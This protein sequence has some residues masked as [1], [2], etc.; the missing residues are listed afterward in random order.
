LN[1]DFWSN[2]NN[3]NNVDGGDS[4]SKTLLNRGKAA[5]PK[6]IKQLKSVGKRFAPT[7]LR[8]APSQDIVLASSSSS[9]SA[10]INGICRSA[11]SSK[12]HMNLKSAMSGASQAKFQSMQLQ[13]NTRSPISESNESKI[14]PPRR[15]S[16]SRSSQRSSRRH[17]LQQKKITWGANDTRTLTEEREEND[18]GDNVTATTSRSMEMELPRHE[19]TKAKKETADSNA[20]NKAL[21]KSSI[22][23]SSDRNFKE[24]RTPPQEAESNEELLASREGCEPDT[25]T[26][27]VHRVK[28]E[29]RSRSQRQ[30]IL[31]SGGA[32]RNTESQN[33]A[34]VTKKQAPLPTLG[35]KEQRRARSIQA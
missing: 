28:K 11:S 2:I 13:E 17:E 29:S 5:G 1:E 32:I 9:S 27:V 34:T 4:L 22:Q 16:P 3:I 24:E 30:K 10:G 6:K 18:H 20:S 23:T 12:P 7:P 35:I 26:V 21:I 31:A 8:E 19:R 33:A 14:S 15:L 25:A